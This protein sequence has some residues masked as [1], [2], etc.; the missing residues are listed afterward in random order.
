MRLITPLAVASIVALSAA[1]VSE[2]AERAAERA[3]KPTAPSP[4]AFVMDV[5]V[6]FEK[7]VLPNGLTLIV[8][9]DHDA[10][11]VATEIWYHVG[12]KN[13][14]PG[15]TGFAH[16]F[17]HLM[18]NGSEN[19][20]DEWFKPFERVGATG[21]N[22][23][24]NTDR[25]NYFQ[26]VPKGALDMTLWLESDRM[27][28]FLGAL[29][30]ATLDEQRGVVQNEKRQNENQPYG[31]SRELVA[32]NVYPQGHPYSW[33]TIGSMD[34]LDAAS[35]DDV[36]E[37][38]RTYYGPANAV[39]VIAG[40]VKASEAKALVEKYFGHIPSGPPLARPEAWTAKMSGEKRATMQD[41]VP[42]ARVSIYWN[43]PEWGTSDVEYLSLAG[44][45]LA[46]GKT[47]R[48]YKRLVYDEQICTD[49][50]AWVWAQ[51]IA[52]QFSISATAKPGQDLA[53]IEAAIKEELA[54]IIQSGPTIAELDRAKTQN[55]AD[56]IRSLE[57]IGGFRGKA[58]ILAASQTLLGSPDAWKRGYQ[59]IMTATPEHVAAA[60]R[61]WLSDGSFVLS[62]TPFP[63]YRT[64]PAAADRKQMP[65][66]GTSPDP[67]FPAMAT[68]ELSNGLRVKLVSRHEVP[69]VQLALHFDAGYAADQHAEPGTASLVGAMLD[70]GT[71]TRTA[72]EISDELARLG[73]DFGASSNT[74]MTTVSMSLLADKLDPSLDVFADLVLNPAFAQADFERQVQQRLAQI[75]REKSDPQ[76]IGFRVLPALVFGKGHAYANPLTGTGTEA[77]V[78]RMTRDSLLAFHRTWFRPDNAT[79]VVVGDTNEGELKPR[80][81]A[82]FA[83]WKPAPVP[84][85]SLGAVQPPPSARVFLVDKP[86]AIQ[87]VILAATVGPPKASPDD[88]AIEAM[89]RVLGGAFSSRINMNL[90]EDKHWSYGARSSASGPRGPRMIYVSAPVQSDK[91]KESMVEVLAELRDIRDGKPVTPDELAK[92]QDA[93]TLT[94]PGRWETASAVAGSIAEIVRFGLPDRYW[95][96]YA[97]SV[98]SLGLEDVSA[99]ASKYLLP[100]RLTWVVIGD[101]AKIEAGIRELDL[102]PI[103]VIDADGTPLPDTAVSQ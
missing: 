92:S 79:L 94:L 34:D 26:T 89:N 74:D 14:K 36:K 99:T 45:I 73:A 12:S 98:R 7:F 75:Q 33:T 49:V 39:L 21:Q 48:L 15:K 1:S 8:H 41:R 19:H 46:S 53:P 32:A 16:L 78:K 25:T 91:T 77:S 17:E 59:E 52:G 67:S 64:T 83:T 69:L 10:P 61:K 100:D 47:S 6:P 43:V 101:R 86:G 23:T 37:W 66:A 72:L 71:A 11:I 57:Q 102:G 51:E 28:H 87:S 56:T 90:R 18:F 68:F 103:Q 20:K 50:R 80:L 24:T 35:L 62:V 97:S 55:R 22:G 4:A 88:L 85:K 31:K 65:V 3:A 13:E 44:E 58:G 82:R 5:D 63:E 40:D 96:T 30:Q 54:G 81:E 93:A 95:D 42:Q 2:A 9:E 27:G 76:S 60:A 38:F 70:E 29:D 84:E